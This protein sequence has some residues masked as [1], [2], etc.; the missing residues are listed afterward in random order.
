MDGAGDNVD[1]DLGPAAED[2]AFGGAGLDLRHR[3]RRRDDL[4][5]D[6]GLADPA[7]DEGGRHWR[8]EVDDEDGVGC[9][10]L[11]LIGPQ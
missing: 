6:V 1:S 2:D 4:R 7:G 10:R 5:I 8:A 9:H 3:D 11:V